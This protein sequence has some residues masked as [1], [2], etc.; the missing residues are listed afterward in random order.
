MQMHLITFYTN[1]TLSFKPQFRAYVGSHMTNGAFATPYG[2]LTPTTFPSSNK[3]S[4]ISVF[5]MKVPPFTA[6][7]LE[8]PY[9]IPPNP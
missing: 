2:P 6:L 8:N 7:I 3:T 4:F 9:G 1:L 5:N